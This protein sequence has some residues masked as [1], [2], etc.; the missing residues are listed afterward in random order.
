MG[1]N[2]ILF[3]IFSLN[4]LENYEYD[5]CKQKS[6]YYQ[7]LTFWFNNTKIMLCIGST[8]DLKVFFEF[9]IL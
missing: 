3:C 7:K 5:L 4:S 8:F 1:Q 9:S 2:K 6:L